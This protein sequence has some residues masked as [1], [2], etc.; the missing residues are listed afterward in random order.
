VEIPARKINLQAND[1]ALA[2]QLMDEV[3]RLREQHHIKRPEAGK[4]V[5]RKP[6]S[7]LPIELLDRRYYLDEPLD[8]S[9]RSQVS[10]EVRAYAD[11]CK[12]VGLEP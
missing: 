12:D 8:G 1:A 6:I 10:K 11:A 9:R 7:F 3:K 5:R 2:Q 4:G